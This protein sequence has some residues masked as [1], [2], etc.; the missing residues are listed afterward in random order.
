MPSSIKNSSIKRFYYEYEIKNDRIKDSKEKSNMNMR[1][2]VVT[3]PIK[4]IKL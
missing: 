2:E 4:R 1:T 3:K